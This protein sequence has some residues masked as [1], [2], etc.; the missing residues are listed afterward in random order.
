[1]NKL[2]LDANAFIKEIDFHSL[3]NHYSFIIHEAIQ[4][5]I[6]DERARAKLNT[7]SYPLTKSVPS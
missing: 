6:R 1:M 2:I 7:F 4:N 3:S 5:E